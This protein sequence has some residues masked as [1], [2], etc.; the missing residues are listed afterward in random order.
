MEALDSPFRLFSPCRYLPHL[1]S[2]SFH[3]R[4]EDHQDHR[5]CEHAIDAG[6]RDTLQSIVSSG[7]S[8]H[9][10]GKVSVLESRAGRTPTLH[11]FLVKTL[12]LMTVAITA[13]RTNSISKSLFGGINESEMEMVETIV[14]STGLV[15]CLQ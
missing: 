2:R 9:S 15:K 4:K 7:R 13:D 1:L 5:S 12:D 14:E 6:R 8:T 11:V 10:D 3:L